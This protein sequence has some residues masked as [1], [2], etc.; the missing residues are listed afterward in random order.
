M[1][2][3][4]FTLLE[5]MIVVAVIGIVAALGV[6][7][8][9]QV[10]GA[11]KKRDAVEVVA[12]QFR[13]LRDRAQ[14]TGGSV[15]L[16]NN[17]VRVGIGVA[18]QDCQSLPATACLTVTSH[19]DPPAGHSSV[20][21]TNLF[22]MGGPIGMGCISSNGNMFYSFTGRATCTNFLPGEVQLR[23]GPPGFLPIPTGPCHDCVVGRKD[24]TIDAVGST[25]TSSCA[26][27]ADCDGRACKPGGRCEPP[28][29]LEQP[30]DAGRAYPN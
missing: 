5:M 27:N 30:G 3:R 25:A 7:A 17:G 19:I 18:A 15:L 6:M 16:V 26:S 13:E 1:R 8:V 10:V 24:G 22:G 29:G 21:V 12:D 4:A 9:T 28:G 2:Q 23:L 11:A 14:S 20:Q